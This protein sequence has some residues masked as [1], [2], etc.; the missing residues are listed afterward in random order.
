MK[1]ANQSGK[2][3]DIREE[4]VD[5]YQWLTIK[6]YEGKTSDLGWRCDLRTEGNR[7]DTMEWIMAEGKKECVICYGTIPFWDFMTGEPGM[8]VKGV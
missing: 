7:K 6:N 4:D 3:W 5:I 2:K 1:K 8:K